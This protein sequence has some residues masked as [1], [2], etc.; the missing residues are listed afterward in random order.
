M[1]SARFGI[2]GCLISIKNIKKGDELFSNYGPYYSNLL[3]P[4]SN[5]MTSW[6]YDCWQKFKT[7]H[8]E[9]IEYIKQWEEISKN[10]PENRFNA[11]ETSQNT[12]P[13]ISS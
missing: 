7:D 10:R 3:K 1:D 13:E 9:E 8:P 6:Y 11:T 4:D 2:I 12:V 5:S